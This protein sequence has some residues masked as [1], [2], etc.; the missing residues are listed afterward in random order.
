MKYLERFK[1]IQLFTTRK[2]KFKKILKFVD[3]LS[4]NKYKHT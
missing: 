4:V 1:N 3:I 2:Y